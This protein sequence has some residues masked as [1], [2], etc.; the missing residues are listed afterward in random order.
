MSRITHVELDGYKGI[1]RRHELGPLTL[2]SGPN[3]LGKSAVLEGLRY[4]LS[5]EVPSGKALDEVARFFPPRG[6]AVL[7]IDADG[8]WLRRGIERDHDVLSA[9]G[10]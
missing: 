9:R 6:G 3:G 4:A 10:A 8:N 7:V 5:G 2:L 1:F